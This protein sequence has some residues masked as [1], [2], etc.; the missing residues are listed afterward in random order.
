MYRK[1]N[2]IINRLRD[3]ERVYET[4]VNDNKIQEFKN[5]LEKLDKLHDISKF[6]KSF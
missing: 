2:T 6:Y 4:F 1:F 5:K 3:L